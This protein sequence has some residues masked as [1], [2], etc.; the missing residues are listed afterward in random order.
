MYNNEIE[1]GGLHK[2]GGHAG[3]MSAGSN[4]QRTAHLGLCMSNV[5]LGR[6]KWF[7]ILVLNFRG[8]LMSCA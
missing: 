5:F 8:R 6:T 7:G 1:V 4:Q 3:R 2:F